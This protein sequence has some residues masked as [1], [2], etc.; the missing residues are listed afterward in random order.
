MERL[1][2]F[3]HREFAN[4]HGGALDRDEGLLDKLK[5]LHAERRANPLVPR[6]WPSTSERFFSL[7]TLHD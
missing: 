4:R 7:D 3:L 2:A 6:D 5:L 1:R